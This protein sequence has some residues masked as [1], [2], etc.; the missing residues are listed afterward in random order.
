MTNET[1]TNYQ[2]F[3]DYVFGDYRN[4]YWDG[5]SEEIFTCLAE[6]ERVKAEKLVLQSIKKIFVDE[7]AIRAAGYLKIREVVP[8]LEKRLTVCGIFMSKKSRSSFVWA[9]LKIKQDKRQLE[10]IIEVVG[11]GTSIPDLGQMDAI[12][13]VS[14]FGEEPIVVKTLLHAFLEKD[15]SVSLPAHY[16]LIK[17]FKDN[18]EVSDLF[19][20]HGFLPPFHIRDSIVKHI[21]FQTGIRH[22][23]VRRGSS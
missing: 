3:F 4:F 2:T 10:K 18:R 15:I 9:L 14:D 22:E 1:S 11:G 5:L 7:R 21:E 13:L 19:K 16:A 8:V 20:L 12:E 17:I 23:I 6:S